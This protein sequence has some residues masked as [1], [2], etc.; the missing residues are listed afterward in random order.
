MTLFG[1]TNST[2]ET[3]GRM[4]GWMEVNRRRKWWRL[5]RRGNKTGAEL[6]IDMCLSLRTHRGETLS[7][8]SPNTDGKQRE[9][10][11]VREN[12]SGIEGQR[13]RDRC[14]Y[15]QLHVLFLAHF[16][17][18]VS[19]VCIILWCWWNVG[20]RVR[21]VLS[22]TAPG[23]L[24]FSLLFFLVKKCQI[25]TGGFIYS[26]FRRNETDLKNVQ[27]PKNHLFSTSKW[28]MRC[29]F[30]CYASFELI[31]VTGP[32]NSICPVKEAF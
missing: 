10:S 21:A 6:Q 5:G 24:K 13:M 17:R 4:D 25:F 18:R 2:R 22:K 31:R 19:K 26:S 7:W 23:S 30:A 12:R 1:T 28:R 11:K 32:P 3:K 15:V 16:T 20:L 14:W 29:F 8:S 9:T 27:N